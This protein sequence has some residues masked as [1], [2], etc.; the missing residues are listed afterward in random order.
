MRILVIDDSQVNRDAAI[1]QLAGHDVEVAATYDQGVAHFKVEYDDANVERLLAER[2]VVKNEAVSYDF[3]YEAAK[4]AAQQ[5]SIVPCG[6]DAVLVD[7]LMPAS[8]HTQG[9]KGMPFVG[10]E[11]PI[12]IFLVLLAAK[13]GAKHV[14]LMTDTDHHSHPASACL[15]PF[16]YGPINIEGATVLLC[17]HPRWVKHYEPDNLTQEMEYEDWGTNQ[18]P[19]VVAK[20]WLSLLNSLMGEPE[21][22]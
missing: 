5:E 3:D 21:T 13:S 7:L 16:A 17:N 11:M 2:G 15:D 10:Q 6:F 8:R 12:G 9:P 18:K 4:N 19:S 1:A 22:D 20:D 14:A